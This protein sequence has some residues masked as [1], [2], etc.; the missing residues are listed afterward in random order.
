MGNT[1]MFVNED[2]S[3]P[4]NRVNLALFSLV[5]QDWF[6]EWILKKLCLPADAV[7]YPPTNVGSR[8]PDFKVTR[9]GS[10]LAMIEVELGANLGQAEDYREKFHNQGVKTIWGKRKAEVT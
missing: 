8:R 10:E 1:D 7:V 4:E 6:R 9:D 2:T 3:K 5:Q